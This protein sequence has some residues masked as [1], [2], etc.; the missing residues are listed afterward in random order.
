[1]LNYGHPSRTA[2]IGNPETQENRDAHRLSCKIDYFLRPNYGE[3]SIA[4]KFFT[5]DYFVR[6]GDEQRVIRRAHG[7]ALTDAITD[8]EGPRS[9]A[10][11]RFRAYHR[12]AA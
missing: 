6:G 8:Q 9:S 11:L 4:S 5:G 3:R 7:L 1:M 10:R 2:Q 12:A